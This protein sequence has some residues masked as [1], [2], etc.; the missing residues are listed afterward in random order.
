MNPSTSTEISIRTDILRDFETE[1]E[2]AQR[3]KREMTLQQEHLKKFLPHDLVERDDFRAAAEVNRDSRFLKHARSQTA[4]QA[5]KGRFKL[6]KQNIFYNRPS[7]AKDS[8]EM[9]V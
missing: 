7:D 2:R 9:V 1:S 8:V 5:P 4:T 3:V 6:G